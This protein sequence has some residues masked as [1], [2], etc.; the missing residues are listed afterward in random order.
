MHSERTREFGD[1]DRH[2]HALSS[3]ISFSPLQHSHTS[4]RHSHALYT[5]TTGTH[6]DRTERGHEDSGAHHTSGSDTH[7][8]RQSTVSSHVLCTRTVTPHHYPSF[9]LS[10]SPHPMSDSMYLP[11]PPI[12]SLY[13]YTPPLL[14]YYHTTCRVSLRFTSCSPL[15]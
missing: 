12:S 9:A 8:R 14:R 6:D 4:E 3:E 2:T 7:I 5:E 15:T 1:E 11:P 10:L 13:Y